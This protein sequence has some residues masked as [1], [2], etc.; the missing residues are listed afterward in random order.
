MWIEW[1]GDLEGPP[2]VR[3]KRCDVKLRSGFIETDV[4]VFDVWSQWDWEARTRR[5]DDIVAF[6]VH[7]VRSVPWWRFWHPQSGLIGGMITM[8]VMCGTLV[9]VIAV[10]ELFR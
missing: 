5:P 6:R 7:P 10:I 1:N 4:N 8:A 9:L 3:G 2:H